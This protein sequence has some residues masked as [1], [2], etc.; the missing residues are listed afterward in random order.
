MKW[1]TLNPSLASLRVEG[2]GMGKSAR[3]GGWASV[4]VCVRV[5]GK[6]GGVW[7][8]MDVRSF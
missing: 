3:V 2:W 4:C 7:Y 6:R 1:N 5:L 8:C